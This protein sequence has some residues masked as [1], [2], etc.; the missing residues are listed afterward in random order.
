M[1]QINER[2]QLYLNKAGQGQGGEGGT[3]KLTMEKHL[4]VSPT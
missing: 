4:S 3:H 1:G 2:G